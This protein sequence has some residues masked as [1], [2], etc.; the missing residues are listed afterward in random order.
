[1]TEPPL[2]SAAD[3]YKE[4]AALATRSA[5]QL[6]EHERAKAERLREEVEQGRE[7]LATSEAEREEVVS[8][9]RKRW[10]HAMEALF[11]EKWMRVTRMPPPD[12]GAEPLASSEAIRRVQASYLQ[13]RETLGHPR[14]RATS[15]LPRR[16]GKDDPED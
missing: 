9:V 11:D 6:R 8:G 15:W 3:R 16:R 13:L 14:W 2:G 4:V 10:D 5:K 1:M 7:R 12:E